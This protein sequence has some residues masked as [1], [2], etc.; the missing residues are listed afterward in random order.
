[1]GYF[2]ITLP[3]D[4]QGEVRW[5]L[6]KRKSLFLGLFKVWQASNEVKKGYIVTIKPAATGRN[7]YRLLKNKEG[8]WTSEDVGFHVTPDDEIVAS[9]KHAIDR[10]ENQ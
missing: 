5:G 6:I 3:N 2:T 10:Y 8:R 1:M 7:E 4:L 9:I